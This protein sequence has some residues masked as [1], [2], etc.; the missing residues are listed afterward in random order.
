VYAGL[1]DEDVRFWAKWF[2]DNDAEVRKMYGLED[3]ESEQ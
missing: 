1:T 2:L 3:P